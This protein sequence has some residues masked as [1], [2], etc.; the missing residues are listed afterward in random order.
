VAPQRDEIFKQK[1][2]DCVHCS[3]Y[4]ISDVVK[5]KISIGQ[6]Q[7]LI[8]QLAKAKAWTFEAKA[9][10]IV[11]RPRPNLSIRLPE[12]LRYEVRLTA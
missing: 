6:C 1:V 10:A 3:A 5:A 7:G 4:N 2:N 8:P 9:K 11:P 12:K